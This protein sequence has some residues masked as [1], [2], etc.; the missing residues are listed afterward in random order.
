M[1]ST[2]SLLTFIRSIN[3]K[4][5]RKYF[6][7]RKLLDSFDWSLEG[8]EYAQGLYGEINGADG[9]VL[10]VITQDFTIISDLANDEGLI[11]LHEIINSIFDK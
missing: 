3:K 8:E 7:P 5:L 10:D 2:F 1:A 6:R 9:N 4:H 11:S